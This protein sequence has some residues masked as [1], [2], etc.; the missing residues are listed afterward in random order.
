MESKMADVSIK[1]MSM[2]PKRE[3]NI[4]VKGLNSE[5]LPDYVTKTYRDLIDL[6][7]AEK[8][9]IEVDASDAKQLLVE[10]PKYKDTDLHDFYKP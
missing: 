1:V 3:Y 9:D 8:I 2:N 6:L 10:N 5:Q 4:K 7:G